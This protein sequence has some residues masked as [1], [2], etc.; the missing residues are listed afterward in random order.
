MLKID[1]FWWGNDD[2]HHKWIDA[3]CHWIDVR[4]ANTFQLPIAHSKSK[5][6]NALSTCT[7]FAYWKQKCHCVQITMVAAVPFYG[8]WAETKRKNNK[9]WSGNLIMIPCRYTFRMKHALIHIADY[10]HIV[11]HKRWQFNV[12]YCTPWVDAKETFTREIDKIVQISNH[13]IDAHQSRKSII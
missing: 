10:T 3:A 9:L 5:N 11:N 4:H 2:I 12:R 8:P 6:L 13:I 7:A 1:R